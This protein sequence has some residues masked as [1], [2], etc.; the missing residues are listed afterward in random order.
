MLCLLT[1]SV[2]KNQFEVH[3]ELLHNA[4][5][6]KNIIIGDETWI[7]GYDGETKKLLL[8]WMG[9]G[10]LSSTKKSMDKS[11]KDQGN[12]D[13]VFLIGKKLPIMNLYH[14]VTW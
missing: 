9:K 10:S 14:V 6:L 8:Q 7:Y 1:D 13:C 11:V 12:V 3:Q 2:K 5:A 4:N